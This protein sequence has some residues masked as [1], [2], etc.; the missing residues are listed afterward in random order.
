MPEQNLQTA[1]QKKRRGFYDEPVRGLS[2]AVLILGCLCFGVG[3]S[4]LAI[5]LTR[6]CTYMDY[7]DDYHY[8]PYRYD[9]LTTTTTTTT[10]YTWTS[11][12]NTP[13][14]YVSPGMWSGLMFIASGI[15]G[16]LAA[17]RKT[18][19]FIVTMMALSL[20]TVWVAVMAMVIGVMA[21]VDDMWRDGDNVYPISLIIQNGAVVLLSLVC[22]ILSLIKFG[23]ACR[24]V[25]CN[26]NGGLPAMK[27]SG[28]LYQ[29]LPLPTYRQ[30]PMVQPMAQPMPHQ[31]NAPMLQQNVAQPIYLVQGHQVIGMLPPTM[32]Q[33]A[34]VVQPAPVATPVVAP[35]VAP[36]V[37]EYVPA[38]PQ[39]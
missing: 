30:S 32:Q 36:T 35:N 13:F 2:I 11:M 22:I 37:T 4:T 33:P 18:T 17:K 21:S 19:C 27:R 1:G 38:P 25:C 23:F 5:A 24:A 39:A 7:H 10:P 14:T 6:R 3:V 16:I 29:P 9:D 31:G 34:P 15:I 20:V 26:G 12:C 28:P 8:D